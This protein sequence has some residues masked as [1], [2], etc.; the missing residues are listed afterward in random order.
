MRK[1]KFEQDLMNGKIQLI[2]MAIL[3]K[4]IQFG[5]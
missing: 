3:L 5:M 2:I 1:E 4:K